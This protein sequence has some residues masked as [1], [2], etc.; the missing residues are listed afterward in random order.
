TAK[1]PPASD[2]P[3]RPRQPARPRGEQAQGPIRDGAE[4][5][6]RPASGPGRLAPGPGATGAPPLLITPDSPP[7]V[8]I[9]D[10]PLDCG[11][12]ERELLLL[13]AKARTAGRRFV[14]AE[15]LDD[16]LFSGYD[17]LDYVRKMRN[18]TI[19]RL[20]ELLGAHV[21]PAKDVVGRRR[22][23]D[24]RRRVEYALS[25]RVVLRFVRDSGGTGDHPGGVG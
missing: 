19:R 14:P 12:V 25:E 15:D 8:R 7:E 17:N 10:E 24:D 6:P 23:R 16:A 11:A 9:G 2:P 20:A 3:E 4:R 5:P 1:R 21:A 13:L 18:Q 22:A